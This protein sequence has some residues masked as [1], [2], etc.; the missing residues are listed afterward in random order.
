LEGN[1]GGVVFV[2]DDT[3]TGI[4]DK[5]NI[6][7]HLVGDNIDMSTLTD[8]NGNYIFQNIPCGKYQLTAQKDG[9]LQEDTD[10]IF[11]HLG[12]MAATIL[13]VK[14]Y[15]RPKYKIRIDSVRLPLEG[16]KWFGLYITTIGN[17]RIIN[18]GYFR[19]HVFF[20]DSS[21]VSVDNYDHH[22]FIEVYQDYS[23]STYYGDYLLQYENNF[24]EQKPG[25]EIIYICIYPQAPFYG[26]HPGWGDVTPAIIRKEY[27][28]PPSDIFS[29]RLNDIRN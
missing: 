5:S 4:A 14:L 8:V 27:L 16:Q 28:G 18:N 2:Y 6:D 25:D 22:L 29:F 15:E 20:N 23:D 7:V 1:I 11:N 10:I 21:N 17:E 13:D 3:Y 24:L 26:E 12:G 9:F 19:S